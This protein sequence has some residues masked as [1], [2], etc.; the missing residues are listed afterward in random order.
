MRSRS[1]F[2]LISITVVALNKFMWIRLLLIIFPL[3]R[4]SCIEKKIKGRTNSTARCRWWHFY[5]KSGGISSTVLIIG[6]WNKQI[7]AEGMV[8]DYDCSMGRL[9]VYE[10]HGC[11]LGHPDTVQASCVR[12]IEIGQLFPLSVSCRLFQLHLKVNERELTPTTHQDDTQN[13]LMMHID[14]QWR[15]SDGST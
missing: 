11:C 14:I 15:F 3:T 12:V 7:K 6:L 10:I 2:R 8:I 4:A 1:V 13:S 5:P 9:A